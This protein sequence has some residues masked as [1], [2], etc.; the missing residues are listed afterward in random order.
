MPTFIND[1][2]EKVPPM[3]NGWKEKTE[4]LIEYMKEKAP[5]VVYHTANALASTYVNV[6]AASSFLMDKA[7]ET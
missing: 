4:P 7:K 3:I 6:K 1:L 2:K 5:S